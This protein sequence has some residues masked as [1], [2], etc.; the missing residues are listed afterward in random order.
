VSGST[1]AG[2]AGGGSGSGGG[3]GNNGSAAGNAQVAQGGLPFTGLHAPLLALFGL[4]M[5]AA[6]LSLR[7]RLNGLG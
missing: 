2:S 5:A 1:G 3:N 7:R 6:G 4:A